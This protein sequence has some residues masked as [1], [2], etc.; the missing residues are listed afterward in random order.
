MPVSA[1]DLYVFRHRVLREAAYQLL[2]PS[3]RA[4][5][6][7]GALRHLEQFAGAQVSV[8]IARELAEHATAALAGGTD[9]GQAH[10]AEVRA[11]QIR[12]LR[13]WGELA[14]ND[15]QNEEAALAWA[16][17]AQVPGV[18][19]PERADA[20]LRAHVALTQIGRHTESIP[21]LESCRALLGC[22]DDSADSMRLR[23]RERLA[24]SSLHWLKA[25]TQPSYAAAARALEL[26]HAAGDL[27]LEAE[28]E[29]SLA[30]VA[31]HW[32]R[33]QESIE[34]ETRALELA[35]KSDGPRGLSYIM[36]R[37]G[38]ALR[39]AGRHDDGARLVGQAIVLARQDAN[40][41]QLL[42]T[43]ITGATVA[44]AT[45][46]VDQAESLLREAMA[47]AQRIGSR[48]AYATILGNYANLLFAA[49]NDL[50]GAETYYL[51][52]VALQRELGTPSGEAVS[53]NNLA[54]TWFSI[55]LFRAALRAWA[56]AA[57][58]ARKADYPLLEARARCFGAG[59]LALLGSQQAAE[60]E[61]SLGLACLQ[62]KDEGKFFIEFGATSALA[63]TLAD[64]ANKD[65]LAM[66]TDTI[67][68]METVAQTRGLQND[69]YS[70]RTLERTR[71]LQEEIAAAST[72][73][74]PPR[75]VRGSL[76]ADLN[77]AQRCALLGVLAAQGVRLDPS[78]EE[79][80]REGTQGLPVPDWQDES[81][82]ER[83]LSPEA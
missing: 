35:R 7:L 4:D 42:S 26:A 59:A 71:R 77:P 49:R 70:R 62:G 81:R 82:A 63:V 53:I 60:Q 46:Q 45:D 17:L 27:A 68:R 37:L 21:P 19:E 2:L 16:A 74:R 43:L 34:R 64:P 47:V 18:A 44:R 3:Q 73:G 65:H 67:R 76:I 72:Q 20:F 39:E 48:V 66:V 52:A 79:A 25:E 8:A 61:I 36:T 9:L 57:A 40:P 12:L 80:L 30:T 69:A 31:R 51:R 14:S 55:G 1:E 78:V 54:F 75:L 5:L 41:R 32:G 23:C 28:A 11:A 15:W 13:Q 83:L 38:M 50:A 6:H 24:Q 33:L 29:T 56:A 58:S 22:L 10:V